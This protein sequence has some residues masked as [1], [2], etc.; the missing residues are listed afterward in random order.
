M[1]DQLLALFL[2]FDGLFIV[3]ALIGEHALRGSET[4]RRD[5]VLDCTPDGCGVVGA[6]VP[7]E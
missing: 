2:S 7:V 1:N 5:V 6:G 3:A 4:L